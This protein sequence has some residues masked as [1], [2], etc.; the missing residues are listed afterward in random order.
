MTD[1][2][3]KR[4]LQEAQTYRPGDLES[5]A[6]SSPDFQSEDELKAAAKE[7]ALP[8]IALGKDALDSGLALPGF[9]G[10]AGPVAFPSTAAMMDQD[11]MFGSD[12][13]IGRTREQWAADAPERYV[14]WIDPNFELTAE[15][16]TEVRQKNNLPGERYSQKLAQARSADELEMLGQAYGKDWQDELTIMKSSTGFTGF[17]HR[18]A[19][20]MLDPTFLVAGGFA[21]SIAKVGASSTRLGNALRAGTSALVSDGT[22]ETVRYF[23]DPKQTVESTG[24]AIIGSVVL[25]SALGSLGKGLTGKEVNE[26]DAMYADLFENPD[27]RGA[28]TPGA[29]GAVQVGEVPRGPGDYPEV[30]GAPA[31]A[32]VGSY[33]T[34]SNFIER[35]PDPA[36]R[37][38]GGNISWNPNSKTGNN[39]AA[40]EEQKR[41][42]ESTGTHFRV[43]KNMR[44]AYYKARGEASVFGG[45]NTQRTGEFNRLVG[46]VLRGATKS[47]DP[48]VLKAVEAT[49]KLIRE[50]VAH[51]QDVNYVAGMEPTWKPVKPDAPKAPDAPSAPDAPKAPDGPPEPDIKPDAP[52]SDAP[53]EVWELKDSNGRTLG[54][55]DSSLEARKALIK[56]TSSKKPGD[57]TYSVGRATVDAP[58]AP[59]APKA[60]GYFGRKSFRTGADAP[61]AEAPVAPE[62]PKDRGEPT[63]KYS[64]ETGEHTVTYPDGTTAVIYK[65]NVTKDWN[66]VEPAGYERV[67]ASQPGYVQTL[68]GTT[69]A[70]ALENLPAKLDEFAPK[71]SASVVTDAEIIQNGRFYAQMVDAYREGLMFK[72]PTTGV[73]ET[74]GAA[75]GSSASAGAGAL[76]EELAGAP[77]GTTEGLAIVGAVLGILGGRA[78]RKMALKHWHENT[79]GIGVLVSPR[80]GDP[81]FKQAQSMAAAGKSRDEIWAATMHGIGPSGDWVT[82]ASD[83][84]GFLKEALTDAPTSVKDVL[85]APNIL[86]AD[87][88][89]REA[90]VQAGWLYKHLTETGHA[91][92]SG[93]ELGDHIASM[94]IN[95][96]APIEKQIG[97]FLHELQHIFDDTQARGSGTNPDDLQG[98]ADPLYAY[99]TNASELSARLAGLRMG[100]STKERAAKGPW[101]S[102]DVPEADLWVSDQMAMA[103][104]LGSH[105]QAFRTP[106]WKAA[107]LIEG[108]DDLGQRIV[109]IKLP[110]GTD[111]VQM[112]FAQ[113][114]GPDGPLEVEWD[115][116]SNDW[117]Q[118]IRDDK[119]MSEM[120]Q[121]FAAVHSVMEETLGNADGQ[122]YVFSGLKEATGN[123]QAALLKRRL[124]DSYEVASAEI[125]SKTELNTRGKPEKLTY[126]ALVPEGK[127]SAEDA[128][129]AMLGKKKPDK[130]SKLE[131]SQRQPIA[132]SIASAD[133]PSTPSVRKAV[134]DDGYSGTESMKDVVH[135]DSYLPQLPNQ[136]GIEQA[137]TRFGEDGVASRLAAL[138]HR[139]ADNAARFD[140]LASRV[141]SKADG[142]DV[143]LRVARK[144]LK[145]FME[146]TDKSAKG[147]SPFRS[148]RPGDRQAAREIVR[149]QFNDGEFFGTDVEE[150]ID[151]IMDLLAP[152]SRKTADTDRAKPRISLDFDE[153]MDADI[154]DMWEW[155][156]EKLAQG[157]A[158]NLSGHSALLRAGY[159]SVA[160]VDA[161]IAKVV[162]NGR[163]DFARKDAREHEVKILK[164]FRDH[165]L[166]NPTNHEDS[167]LSFMVDLMR[168]WNY[169][170][171]MNN[172]GFLSLSEVASSLITVGPIRFMREI[173]EFHRYLKASRSGDVDAIE[174]L[175]YLADAWGGHA[176]QGVLAS[177]GRGMD[178]RGGENLADFTSGG[179]DSL[180][181]RLDVGTRKMANVTGRLS[182]MQGITAMLRSITFNGTLDAAV[183][184]AKTGKGQWTPA[185]MRALG[186]DDAMWKRI[187]AE[188]LSKPNRTLDSGRER[189]DLHAKHWADTEALNA[190][191]GFADRATRRVIQEGEAGTMP[192]WMRDTPLGK[193]LTQFL[194]FPIHA[195]SK[196]LG[197]SLSVG[198]TRAAA[199]QLAMTVGGY[200]GYISR[201]YVAAYATHSVVAEREAYLEERLSLANQAR[202]TIYYAPPASILP[203]VVDTALFAADAAGMG[204]GTQF[205]NARA[206]SM[207]AN[208]WDGNATISGIK[209]LGKAVGNVASGTP[210]SR[211]DIQG[212]MKQGP[213]GNWIP[214]VA[215]V[216]WASKVRPE[217][218]P[219]DKKTDNEDRKDFWGPL[220]N[221]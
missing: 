178:A 191:I 144:Y 85:L 142:Y 133:T 120:Q 122:V 195:G 216:E 50:Q 130:V 54:Q 180:R 207:P 84:M 49:R 98:A 131:R 68:L 27:K 77:E 94:A 147:D 128:V 204:P 30:P 186:V 160:E 113:I 152:V 63:T 172:V 75:A 95:A 163:L 100:M 48:H 164:A 21:G 82:E 36:V 29:A 20:N 86:K 78:S 173:P 110:T 104:S 106:E 3:Y 119:S 197:F 44:Q 14:Q 64:R 185:R 102:Y 92:A 53:V 139:S 88:K 157:Y 136:H 209:S 138:M 200:L 28:N 17:L 214:M 154:I 171:A 114:D 70:E 76:S 4:L 59:E 67:A 56:K 124:P 203:N 123:L 112:R 190:F 37:E 192:L 15:A 52:A 107:N 182:G 46:R 189:I 80:Q 194:A 87:P 65:D 116:H 134:D 201:V 32:G 26:I 6:Q 43:L 126:F 22:L 10:L 151:M 97:D 198:D 16:L 79:P 212:L 105:L 51:A 176:S 132:A 1:E 184:W 90:A 25:S 7:G 38:L 5:V 118:D 71:T 129:A 60:P 72:K 187:Q 125:T 74:L 145:T 35:S 158:R 81:R 165:V 141:G 179:P 39:R 127:G 153:E 19:V 217:E 57:P 96:D 181:N 83:A 135:D 40:F 93:K 99:L 177:V 61:T 55:F 215:L 69:K 101:H 12:R 159:R 62:A 91:G 23:R 170:R 109:D 111:G 206:S 150:A 34:P 33:G 89:V 45:V 143:A 193:I 175:H 58:A 115:W 208:F 183:K 31:Q 8:F 221:K 219:A 117:S 162:S 167:T 121:A 103:A 213:L 218:D 18:T 210:L 41:I 188:I 13:E 161:A 149:E 47:E 155:D 202:S 108:V 9:M 137:V 205:Q 220:Y 166:G 169:S 211:D 168:R 148:V 24:I 196:Q 11:F 73:R 42:Y 146:L 199:E 2:E 140:K 66:I 156:A 174:E